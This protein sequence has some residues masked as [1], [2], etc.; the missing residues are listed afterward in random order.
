MTALIWLRIVVKSLYLLLLLP[1]LLLGWLARRILY[2]IS[3][4]NALRRSGADPYAVR[5]LSASLR[6]VSPRVS[7]LTRCIR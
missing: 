3:F 2:H 6:Q 1:Y 7:E 5:V 4:R